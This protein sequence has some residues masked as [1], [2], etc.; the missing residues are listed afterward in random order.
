MKIRIRGNSIRFR[1]T[2][3]E[4]K[5]LCTTGRCAENTNFGRGLFT[6]SV[7]VTDET[8]GMRAQLEANAISLLIAGSLIHDWYEN[9]RVGFEER[10][11]LKYGEELHLLLEKDFVCMDERAEDESDNYPNPKLQSDT[12]S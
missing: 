10:L 9:D 1:L 11:Q 6:Y 2:K 7:R 3:S 4:V 12:S 8:K 5:E